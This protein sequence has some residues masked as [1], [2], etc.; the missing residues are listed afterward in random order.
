MKIS[1]NLRSFIDI[2]EEEK[3]LRR[4]SAEVDWNLEIGAITRR[5]VDTRGPAP[6]FENIKGY[7][8][9]YRIL[10]LPFGPSSPLHARLSLSLGMERDTRPKEIIEEVQSRLQRNIKPKIVSH[11]PCK[12]NIARGDEVNVLNFPAPY[13]HSVD[14]G[15]YIG[16]WCIVVTKDRENG[17]QNWGV[18]R[19]MVQNE[20]VVSINYEINARQHGGDIFEREESQHRE[21]SS[22]SPI[23]IVLGAGP[24]SLLAAAMSPPAGVNESGVASSLLGAPLELVKCET[25]DLEVPAS[26]EIVIEGEVP[27][28][29]RMP[30]GPMGEFSGYTAGGKMD[31]PY[32]DVKCITWRDDPVITLAN[33]GKPWDDCATVYT[34]TY[35]AWIRKILQER[36]LPVKDV[37]V[38]PVYGTVISVKNEHEPRIAE[39]IIQ[40]LKEAKCRT[41]LV[42]TFIVNGDIDVTSLEDVFWC[43]TTR[44]HPK[45][46]IHVEQRKGG[47]P[48]IPYR[49]P[50]ER[51]Q[52]YSFTGYF[53]CTWPKDWSEEYLGEHCRVV[54]FENA[55]PLEMREKVLARWKEYGL[56]SN[57]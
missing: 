56:E 31:L 3:E 57:R 27:L 53:D 42:Y 55:W 2:L 22:A 25:V 4:I 39:K 51:E 50:E 41:G 54:D 32:V 36:G 37:Y 26:S 28:G 52:N 30:E 35:S 11:T 14:G 40:T 44:C 34:V 5:L 19:V 46:G 29:K 18:Y 38:W 33:M 1:D 20:K 48:L 8:A 47:S 10:G 24:I 15:R 16:T 12:E 6:L 23:A 7:P 9:G 13:I 49:T 17:W 45:N 43:L 21:E